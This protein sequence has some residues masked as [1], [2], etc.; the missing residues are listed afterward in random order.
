MGMKASKGKRGRYSHWVHGAM[1][2]AAED[3]LAVVGS[4]YT[5]DDLDRALGLPGIL[6]RE[7]LPIG[8]GGRY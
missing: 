8:A 6:I 7:E 4:G 3:F 2:C 5:F 1:T